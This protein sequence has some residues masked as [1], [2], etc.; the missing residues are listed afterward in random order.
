MEWGSEK[1]VE[2]APREG[3]GLGQRN[4]MEGGE[5]GYQWWGVRQGAKERHENQCQSFLRE[6]KNND[7][8]ERVRAGHRLWEE[9]WGSG[10]VAVEKGRCSR[11]RMRKGV[12]KRHRGTAG[13]ESTHA[14]WHQRGHS[15][16]L[17]TSN[18]K[19]TERKRKDSLTWGWALQGS[20]GGQESESIGKKVA[21][22]R[23]NGVQEEK[24]WSLKKGRVRGRKMSS[25]ENKQQ[26]HWSQK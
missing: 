18:M 24:E 25:S 23:H 6:E 13:L 9:C 2:S 14:C 16:W 7:E 10:M 22:G 3:L 11:V 17:P 21:E 5:Q 19:N 12:T 15:Q 4:R 1:R 8:G 26:R 20:W